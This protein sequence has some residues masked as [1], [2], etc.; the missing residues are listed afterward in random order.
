MAS[1]EDNLGNYLVSLTKAERAL[2]AAQ[3]LPEIKRIIDLASAAK[4]Y[5]KAASLGESAAISAE[6]IKLQAQR[7]AGGLLEWLDQSVQQQSIEASI[8]ELN[9]ILV[10]LVK[11]GHGSSPVWSDTWIHTPMDAIPAQF[12][13]SQGEGIS[14]AK[15]VAS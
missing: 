13:E 3:T 5:A 4:E 8:P 6:K 14:R 7:K 2:Q 12:T 1:Q 10:V 15:P 9:A 11:G